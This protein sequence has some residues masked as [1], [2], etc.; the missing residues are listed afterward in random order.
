MQCEGCRSAPLSFVLLFSVNRMHFRIMVTKQFTT[1]RVSEI[2]N[3]EANRI[4]GKLLTRQTAIVSQDYIQRTGDLVAALSSNPFKVRTTDDTLEI[5][6]KYPATIRFL[7]LRKTALGKKK[8]YY[9]AIYNRPLFGHIY[10]SG[11]SLTN[12]INLTA[13]GQIEEFLEG[14]KQTQKSIEL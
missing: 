11:Y 4:I 13:R 8:S 10:G 6:I 1:G 3:K 2:V 14:L 7:D 5:I 9:T 12:M